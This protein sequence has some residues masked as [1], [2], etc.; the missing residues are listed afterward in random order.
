[1]FRLEV[2]IPQTD[3]RRLKTRWAY[4]STYK[5]AILC[6]SGFICVMG[7]WLV[8]VVWYGRCRQYVHEK[9]EKICPTN[10][11]FLPPARRTV[12]LAPVL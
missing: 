9:M 6:G 8:V 2:L 12:V 1:M 10:R 5:L 11:P 4:E 7:G 3:S